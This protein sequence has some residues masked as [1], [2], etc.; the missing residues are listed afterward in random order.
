MSTDQWD[1]LLRRTGFSGIDGQVGLIPDGP[2]AANVMLST[3]NPEE[4]PTYPTA[5]VLTSGH[6][7][8]EIVRTVA[9]MY[10]RVLQ[11]IY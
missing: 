9:N 10:A 2:G 6:T 8:Q 3:A 4:P 1:S 5:A 11:G 7:E